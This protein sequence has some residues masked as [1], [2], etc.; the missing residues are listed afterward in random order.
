MPAFSLPPAISEL[1]DGTCLVTYTASLGKYGLSITYGAAALVSLPSDSIIVVQ[2]P[3]SYSAN[4]T[5]VLPVFP[6]AVVAGTPC[7]A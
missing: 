3:G 6:D 2:Q 5:L 4:K 7:K 1:P